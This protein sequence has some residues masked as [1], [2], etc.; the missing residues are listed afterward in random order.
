MPAC[1][2]CPSSRASAR[3]GRRSGSTRSRWR[4][5]AIAPWPLGLT[6]AIYGAVAIV[7]TGWF[8]LLALRV[9]TRTTR[10]SDTM[11]PEKRLFAYSIVYLFV[12]FGAVVVDRWFA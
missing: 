6:G 3:R 5:A 9:A 1:R 12:L 10:E 2:C 7:A 11:R 4:S 8:A